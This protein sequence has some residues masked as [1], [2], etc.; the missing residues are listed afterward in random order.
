MPVVALTD[1]TVVS[2]AGP[3][4]EHLLQNIV[5]TDLDALRPGEAK[6]GALLTPQGKILFDFLVSRHGADGFRLDVRTDIAEDFRRR[7]MLYKL[8]AKADI[9]VEDQLLV[10]AAWGDDSGSSQN[11]SSVSETDSAGLRDTRFPDAAVF[12]VYG[13]ATVTADLNDWTRL[14]IANAVVESGSDYALSDAFPHDVLLDQMDGIGMRK[15]CYVGQ[16]VI[17][18]MHHRGTARRRVLIV[19]GEATLPAQGTELIAGGKSIGVLGT[20]AGK[21]G[22]AIARIDRVKDAMDSGQPI[23]AGETPVSLRIPGWARFTFPEASE[24]EQA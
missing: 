13:P 18:R 6:P 7:L 9:S 22:L 4:A 12:R 20:V 21:N 8:R 11:D 2:V 24:P 16:E 19:D 5:T 17:S 10:S 1:R 3:D 23:T 15:G 14:R